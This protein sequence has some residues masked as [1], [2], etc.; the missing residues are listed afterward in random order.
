MGEDV[1]TWLRRQGF[2]HQ[3]KVPNPEGSLEFKIVKAEQ[4]VASIPGETP[5]VDD[6]ILMLFFLYLVGL[7]DG[8][9]S[10]MEIRYF[11]K[12]IPSGVH[13]GVIEKWNELETLWESMPDNEFVKYC[14]ESC[15]KAMSKNESWKAKVITNM[16][17]M[18][19]SDRRIYQEELSKVAEIA[20]EIGAGEECRKQLLK[21]FDWDPDKDLDAKLDQRDAVNTTQSQKSGE[22][23]SAVEVSWPTFELTDS[24]KITFLA[25][26]T[27]Y[28]SLCG[29]S[30][31][32]DA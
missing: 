1:I 32:N 30:G 22:S 26:Y 4:T 18:A 7:S 19:K 16:I 24:V 17:Q 9:F 11:Y 15:Q 25:T 29:N 14:E 2:E 27:D 28:C 20:D 5:T 10:P 13:D 23:D 3:G 8:Y 6:C 12:C 31:A 21:E